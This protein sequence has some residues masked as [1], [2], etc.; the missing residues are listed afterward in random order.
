MTAKVPAPSP[1]VNQGPPR[2]VA[3]SAAQ[4][5]AK[6]QILIWLI[7]G[8]TAAAI[9][10]SGADSVLALW[11]Y[12]PDTTTGWGHLAWQLRQWGAAVP[13]YIAALGLVALAWPAL[14][15]KAPEL[16]HAGAVMALAAILGAGLI[17]QV[18]VQNVADRPRPRET[19][20]VGTAPTALPAEFEG[21]S[22]PSGHAG[23][24]FTLAAPAFAL[25]RR[26]KLATAIGLAGVS[27]GLAVGAGRMVLGAHYATDVLIAGAITLSTAS[28]VATLMQ[29]PHG[30]IRTI[31]WRWLVAGVA[32]ATA[33]IIGGNHFKVT[34]T[35]SLPPTM[36]PA[37]QQLVSALQSGNEGHLGTL[38]CQ[39][40]PIFSNIS[41]TLIVH[42]EG[43]GAP[44]STI[45]L[46]EK[47][48]EIYLSHHRGLFHSLR[49]TAQLPSPPLT[50]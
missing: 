8:G 39:P 9:G 12:H 49:C 26:P 44:I 2:W 36:G 11:A 17:N 41:S 16:Y 22:M 47:N 43:Y 19:I 14:A 42:I 48:G 31:G 5:E 28:V 32:V 29:G 1:A 30:T 40:S 50:P 27:A 34:L 20:L 21:N 4:A 35:H 18:L 45:Q 3:R 37:T 33:A 24:A 13:G 23:I 15:R 7:F 46:Y 10:L 25:R 38:R 6:R